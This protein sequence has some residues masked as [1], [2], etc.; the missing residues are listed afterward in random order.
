MNDLH[1]IE[2]EAL[3][4]ELLDAG[5]AV[6]PS[7]V[8]KATTIIQ[9]AIEKAGEEATKERD[10]ARAQ[11]D[12]L[13]KECERIG[14]TVSVQIGAPITEAYRLSLDRA[15][16]VREKH[17][18]AAETLEAIRALNIHIHNGQAKVILSI[19]QSAIE[20][21]RQPLEAKLAIL[22]PNEV[23]EIDEH[24]KVRTA[25]A[26]EKW[27][28]PFRCVIC[29]RDSNEAGILHRVSRKGDT[30][31]VIWI[32]HD[33]FNYED[34]MFVEDNNERIESRTTHAKDP[35]QI[36][37]EA[38]KEIASKLSHANVTTLWIEDIIQSAIEKATAHF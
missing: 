18:I 34:W 35:H 19:I 4:R 13:I 21:A 38:A 10:E 25:H 31:P 7:E 23:I 28:K 5:L 17:Q 32:C 33:H 22:L 20:K 27:I 1:Q 2:A 30:K 3:L 15:W 29:G 14:V 24:G 16:T 8:D 36:A 6:L 9:S 11:R 37:A 12:W 26:S